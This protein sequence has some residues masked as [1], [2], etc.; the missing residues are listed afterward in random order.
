MLVHALLVAVILL[1]SSM[2]SQL[3]FIDP[4]T[5]SA[6]VGGGICLGA[7]TELSK[8]LKKGGGAICWASG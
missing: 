1:D 3:R 7:V 8:W 6:G 5:Q 2:R 4:G